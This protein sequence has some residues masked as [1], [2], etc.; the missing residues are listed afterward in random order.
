MLH[1]IYKIF[2][3]CYRQ[4][5]VYCWVC[6]AIFADPQDRQHHTFTHSLDELKNAKYSICYN[7]KRVYEGEDQL[8]Y[9]AARCL[10]VPYIG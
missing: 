6:D 4:K 1:S 10:L 9:H 2:Y 5:T 8:T 3:I 7:C